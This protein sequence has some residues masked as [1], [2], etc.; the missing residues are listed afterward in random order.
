MH[1]S[2]FLT[3]I[4]SAIPGLGHYYLGQMTRGLQM[5]IL[6]FGSMFVM[7]FL[8][9]DAFPVILPIIWFYSLFDALQQR[10]IM[11][12]DQVQIDPPL[13]QWERLK[14]EKHWIGWVLI[15]LGIYTLIEKLTYLLGWQY[16]QTVR[17]I[18]VSAILIFIGWSMITGRRIFPTKK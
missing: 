7:G 15:I 9:I 11:E 17:T 12:E 4:L 13:F 8:R 3:F 16:Y 18:L 6:A 5:M 10:R 14:F 1:K 2:R